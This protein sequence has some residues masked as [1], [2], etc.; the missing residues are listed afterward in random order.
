MT[1]SRAVLASAFACWFAGCSAPQ[2]ATSPSAMSSAPGPAAA[3]RVTPARIA[4]VVD[5]ALRNIEGARVEI[6]DGPQTGRVLTTDA[7]GRF[8]LDGLFS[9]DNTFRASKAGYV[10]VTQGFRTSSA[11]GALWLGFYLQSV[12]APVSIEGDYTL[13]LQADSTCADALPSELRTRTYSATVRPNPSLM[14][15]ADTSLA[16]AVSDVPVLENLNGFQIGVA[17]K[18]LAF[19]LDG[20]HDPTLVERLD[21]STY[22][23]YSGIGWTTVE[24]SDPPTISAVFEGWI[25]YCV[26]A[27]PMIRYYACTTS[28]FTGAPIPG[29]MAHQRCEATRHQIRLTRKTPASPR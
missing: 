13:M 9:R 4:F 21:T 22:L 20:S 1:R 5:A 29:A 8:L 23:A 14:G 7:E 3:Q 24:S 16:L 12:E 28:N 19:W 17:G 11:G 25:D 15:G 2:T 6:L 10:T 27:S 18:T 26:M